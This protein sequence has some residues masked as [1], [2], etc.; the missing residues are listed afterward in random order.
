M[1]WWRHGKE[2]KDFTSSGVKPVWSH[3]L[4]W[5]VNFS[6]KDHPCYYVT[7]SGET[8]ATFLSTV[9]LLLRTIDIK[10]IEVLMMINC[11]VSAAST[12]L[13]L[14]W[15]WWHYCCFYYTLELLLI[16]SFNSWK[17]RLDNIR[18]TSEIQLKV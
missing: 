12:K 2:G 14:L 10:A 8:G 1:T 17:R 5:Y 11:V 13:L 6:L 3:W 7:I 4:A 9:N 18:E 15:W 16:V